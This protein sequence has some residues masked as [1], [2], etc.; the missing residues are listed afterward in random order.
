MPSP[1]PDSRQKEQRLRPVSINV[2]KETTESNSSELPPLT[3][4]PNS[5]VLN[6]RPKVTKNEK[7]KVSRFSLLEEVKA[8]RKQTLM[9]VHKYEDT[10]QLESRNFAATP[11]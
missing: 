2:L 11:F 5:P 3:R 10:K 9:D 1:S 6:E 7:G 4:N 8:G